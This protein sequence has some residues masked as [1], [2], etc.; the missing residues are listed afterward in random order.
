MKIAQGT[1]KVTVIWKE[2]I[3]N[4]GKKGVSCFLVFVVVMILGGSKET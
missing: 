2:N 1:K 3:E 4:P